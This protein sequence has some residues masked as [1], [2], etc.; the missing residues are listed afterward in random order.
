MQKVNVWK[1]FLPGV[2]RQ[3]CKLN[4]NY[5][6]LFSFMYKIHSF[7]ASAAMPEERARKKFVVVVVVVA[8]LNII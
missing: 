4:K 2:L 5:T 6:I 8:D 7:R 3:L 1:T